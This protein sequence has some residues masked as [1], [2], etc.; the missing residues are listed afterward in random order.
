MCG[1]FCV[2]CYL[3]FCLFVFFIILMEV[4]GHAANRDGIMVCVFMRLMFVFC[5]CVLVTPK[6]MPVAILCAWCVLCV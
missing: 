4:N 2:Y 3:V 5:V 6:V 1:V